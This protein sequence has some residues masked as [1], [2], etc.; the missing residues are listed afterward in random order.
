MAEGHAD[1]QAES[2]ALRLDKWLW[3]AR[4]FKTRTLAARAIAQGHLEVNG[5]PAK[6]SRELR[7]GDRVLIREAGLR[8]ELRVLRLS[9]VRGPATVAR[10]LYEETAESQQRRQQF[11]QSLRMGVEPALSRQGGRPTKRERRELT[12][13]QRWTASLE[14]EG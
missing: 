13:W 11:Q 7:P 4:F 2:A 5:A 1:E 6:A 9:A 10:T 3:A 14:P 12:P 8:R